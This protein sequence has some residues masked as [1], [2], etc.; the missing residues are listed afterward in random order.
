M[1]G[2]AI[3][4]RTSQTDDIGRTLQIPAVENLKSVYF[5]SPLAEIFCFTVAPDLLGGTCASYDAEQLAADAFGA[6][7]AYFMVGGTTSA[8]TY[9]A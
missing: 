9:N 7:H 3:V 8:A 5:T 4:A 1:N 6:A 2:G